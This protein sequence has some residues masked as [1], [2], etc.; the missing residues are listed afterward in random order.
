MDKLLQC[1]GAVCGGKCRTG[2]C[3]YSCPW[4]C[5]SRCVRQRWGKERLL[6]TLVGVAS[7]LFASGT[8]YTI[9]RSFMTKLWRG[10]SSETLMQCGLWAAPDVLVC[11]CVRTYVA[12]VVGCSAH[13]K[14][15]CFLWPHGQLVRQ[16]TLRV[17]VSK[18]SLLWQL[19]PDRSMAIACM[20]CCCC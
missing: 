4:M 12:A 14:E 6:G 13:G 8:S 7:L 5:S 16:H 17:G 19:H 2:P 11:L 10:V 18:E 15:W 20:V 3:A 1:S 9:R